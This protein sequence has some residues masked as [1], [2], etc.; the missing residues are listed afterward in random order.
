MVTPRRRAKHLE[1]ARDPA[2]VEP[3]L[4]PAGRLSSPETELP[5]WTD[6]DG[7]LEEVCGNHLK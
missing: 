6:Q 4:A 5:K 7:A 2:A 1:T 3:S